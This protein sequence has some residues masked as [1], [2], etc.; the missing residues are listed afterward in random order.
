MEQ[1]LLQAQNQLLHGAHLGFQVHAQV[2]RDLI[3]AA[4]G[5]V[6]ALARLAQA[7]CQHLFDEHVYVLG[8]GVERERAR[9]Q[10]VEYMLKLPHD[11]LA[12]LLRDDPA[13]AQH[14][15]M[16]HTSLNI[17]FEHAGVKCQR[18]VEIVHLFIRLLLKPARP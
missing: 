7:L 10:L 16:G 6:Q 9:A 1:P 8:R 18:R 15:G 13:R 4:A 11:R 14:G 12:V 17:L 3:V 2:E 5:R